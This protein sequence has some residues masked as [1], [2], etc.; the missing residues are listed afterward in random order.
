MDF[1]RIQYEESVIQYL[2]ENPDEVACVN[3]DEDSILQIYSNNSYHKLQDFLLDVFPEIVYSFNSLGRNIVFSCIDENNV[4]L[5]QRVL[6][7]YPESLRAVDNNGVTPIYY[8]LQFPSISTVILETLL[9]SYV[10]NFVDIEEIFY[11]FKF[12]CGSIQAATLFLRFFP[13]LYDY[14]NDEYGTILHLAVR[15]MYNNQ[16][17]LVRL[18]HSGRPELAFAR[19]GL[20]RTPAHLVFNWE[21]LAF[22]I[23]ECPKCI[24]CLDNK[25]R[26]PLHCIIRTIGI[27]PRNFNY[28]ALFAQIRDVL[29]FK[30]DR[31]ITPV[32]MATYNPDAVNVV[33]AIIKTSPES[34]LLQDGEGMT[35]LHYTHHKISSWETSWDS[36]A[37]KIVEC[38]PEL[39]H[40]KN[41][42]GK[43]P[44]DTAF[45][46]KGRLFSH[47][48]CM[49]I[50]VERFF[51]TCLEYTSIP[52]K[53]WSVFAS[54]SRNVQDSF[55]A[56]LRRSET[57]A[58]RAFKHLYSR[59][60]LRTR[61]ILSLEKYM[62]KNVVL[63]I[64]EMS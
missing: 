26:T 12:A 22:F 48:V 17:N 57:D 60:K 42:Y 41:I 49:N 64:L 28:S 8:E 2:K 46:F 1:N 25:R 6:A 4:R 15:R 9:S 20:G 63:R 39:L 62:T 21:V 3:D 11:Y 33:S 16:V 58:A 43:T 29:K 45:E 13:D 31:G 40:V 35:C 51:A 14:Y 61:A 59:E 36:V 23:S 30:D 54:T 34:L 47:N 37:R 18:I 55:R 52:D 24:Y 32:M 38:K 19:D 5:L 7:I 44:M 10:N 50:V 53:F 27:R 56:I